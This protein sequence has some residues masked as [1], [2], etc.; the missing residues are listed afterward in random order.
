MNTADNGGTS[1][2]RATETR[3]E[4]HV[5][6]VHESSEGWEDTPT[7]PRIRTTAGQGEQDR[8]RDDE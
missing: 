3:I 4:E 2:R 7:W 8:G 5:A 6:D 1:R